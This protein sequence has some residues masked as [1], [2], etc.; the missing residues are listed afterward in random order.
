MI[1]AEQ[2]VFETDAFQGSTQL[3][4]TA[5]LKNGLG[6]NAWQHA[7]LFRQEMSNFKDYPFDIIIKLKKV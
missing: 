1:F 6:D 7:Q 5:K 2:T 3:E 4:L